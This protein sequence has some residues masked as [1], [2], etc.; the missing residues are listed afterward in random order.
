[1]PPRT[2]SRNFAT[3]VQMEINHIN[4]YLQANG[5]KSMYYALPLENTVKPTILLP[6]GSVT[7]AMRFIFVSSDL[8]ATVICDAIHPADLLYRLCEIKAV[9][10]RHLP[11]KGGVNHDI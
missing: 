2:G 5:D 1:M 4:D 10:E 11:P 6:K 3:Q 7:K 8:K 9:L